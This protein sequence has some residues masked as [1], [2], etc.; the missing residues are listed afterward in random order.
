MAHAM[1]SAMTAMIEGIR[2]PTR[3][4]GGK[5]RPVIGWREWVGLPELG[6]E[7]IKAKVDTGARS[8]ALHAFRLKPFRRDGDLWVQFE[9][10]PVQ[11][12]ARPS[13]PCELP[14]RDIRTVTNSGGRSERRY[15]VETL[16][17]LGDAVWHVEVTL[18]NRDQMGFRML[19]GRT[20][21]R[22]R[23]VVDPARSYCRSESAQSGNPSRDKGANP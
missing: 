9:A 6:I 2:K 8:C 7:R 20:A 5:T 12:R 22:R 16:L 21:L 17:R 19:L 1:G 3:K 15:V 18:T 4:Q 10:H 14:V 13:V 11:R 23:F